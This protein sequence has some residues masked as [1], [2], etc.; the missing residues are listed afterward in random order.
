MYNLAVIIPSAGSG[1]RFHSEV[2]K[3]FVLLKGEPILKRTVDRFASLSFVKQI[4]IPT[5][6][7]Y[8]KRTQELFRNYDLSIK[9]I[10]GGKERQLSVQK[11]IRHLF[12]DIDLIAVHDAVRPI[13]THEVITRCCDIAV[14][15]GGAVAGIKAKDTIKT[16]DKNNFIINTP[17]RDSLW[18]CQTPQIFRKEIFIEAFDHAEKENFLGTDDA[19]VVE[20]LGKPVKMV[21]GD[22]DNIKI[23]YPLD[24]KIA[25][26]LLENDDND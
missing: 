1:R 2:S 19:S 22:T 3:P 15:E 8:I 12:S 9:I 26:L 17:D 24:L 5:S 18:Q 20:F 21:E 11:A 13:I 16:V 4:V 6:K 14:A 7:E 23:T 10:E 25:E